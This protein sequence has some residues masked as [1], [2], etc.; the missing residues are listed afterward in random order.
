MVSSYIIYPIKHNNS[1]FK[2]ESEYKVKLFLKD[3]NLT[4]NLIVLGP[5]NMLILILLM[6]I[7]IYKYCRKY[8]PHR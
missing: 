5:L 6:I 1:T 8:S 7:P 4:D 2:P 3:A